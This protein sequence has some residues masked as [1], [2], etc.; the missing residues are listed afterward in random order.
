MKTYTKTV[1]EGEL[2]GPVPEDYD[3][4]KH[5][6]SYCCGDACKQAMCNKC[7]SILR[8]IAEDP[9]SWEVE[10]GGYWKQLYAVGMYDGWPYWKP[11]PAVRTSGVLGP[12]W[13]FFYDLHDC[14]RI[15]AVCRDG[16]TLT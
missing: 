10:V 14:R 9:T 16:R 5:F 13:H 2:V 7:V 15:S 12:E 6:Q 11:T 1:R 4:L 3:F 8:S